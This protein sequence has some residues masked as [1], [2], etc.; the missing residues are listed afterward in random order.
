MLFFQFKEAKLFSVD[1]RK[2]TT[3]FSDNAFDMLPWVD[4]PAHLNS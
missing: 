4:T 2:A 1:F 3:I